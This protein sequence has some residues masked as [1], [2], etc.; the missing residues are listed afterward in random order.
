LAAVA[1]R[2][3]DPSSRHVGRIVDPLV[4]EDGELEP[5]VSLDAGLPVEAAPEEPVTEAIGEEASARGSSMRDRLLERAA[6][7]RSPAEPAAAPPAP[8][9]DDLDEIGRRAVETRASDHAP[10][11]RAPGAPIPGR[12]ALSPTVVALFGTLMGMAVIASVTAIA[13]HVAPHRDRVAEPPSSAPPPPKAE[14][15]PPARPK[16]K[17]RERVRLPGPFRVT[18]G[19]RDPTTKLVEGKIGTDSFLKAV[20]A[21]GIPLKEAYRVV[22]AFKGL[23]DFDHCKKTDRFVALLDRQTQRLKAFEYL[24]GPEEVYQAREGA[25]GLLSSTKLD[26]KVERAPVAGAF[27]YDGKSL[28]DSAE[29]AGFERGVG[30]VILS[31]LDGHS[32]SD[33][34]ERGDVIRLIVQEVTVLGDFARYAGVEAIE[35]KRKT[36]DAVRVYYLDVPGERGYYDGKGRSPHSGGWR[37]PIPGAPITSRFNLKRLHPILKKVVPHLGIDFGAPSGTPIGA[38]APGTI[39]FIGYSG[40]AGN[41]VKVAHPGGVETGYAHLSRFVEGMKVGQK[42]KRLETIGYVGSTGRS[43]GPH[44]H[45]SATKNKEYFDPEKLDLDGM[46]TLSGALRLTFDEVMVKYNGLLDAIPLPEPLVEEPP[47]ASPP[48]A[49]PLGSALPAPRPT[50]PEHE[51]EEEALAPP[52]PLPAPPPSSA[53]RRAGSSIYL[54]DKELLELQGATDDGEVSE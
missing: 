48:P 20:E 21:A 39:T 50:T 14:V 51:E 49:A 9:A 12:S 11:P 44:L 34:L 46:R 23:R 41:L 3:T 35:L 26:L 37:K 10:E 16:P 43:T 5:E 2:P 8:S 17:K 42:V 22:T 29:H 18:D 45:F 7:S 28:D 27:V 52:P 6:A 53:P 15:E 32:D 4:R 25:S 1:S 13:M 30:R 33:D 36:G 31:A 40:P 19:A 54:T 24:V 38:S 47:P